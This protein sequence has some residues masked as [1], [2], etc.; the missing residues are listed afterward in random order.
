MRDCTE[1]SHESRFPDQAVLAWCFVVVAA[2]L[3][4]W[5]PLQGADFAWHLQIG[6]VAWQ[7]KTMLPVEIFSF[8]Q[9]GRPWL[10]KD[11][12]A[13]ILL[14]GLYSGL[15]VWGFWLLKIL[16]LLTIAWAYHRVFPAQHRPA[17][18]LL[19]CLLGC[20][21]IQYRVL[22][23][24]LLFSLVCF[25]LMVSLLE[26]LRLSPPQTSSFRAIFSG[27][28]PLVL[29]Q[30]IWIQLHRGALLG[31]AI[32]LF[33]VIGFGIA[34]VTRR[35]A[36]SK[37]LWGEAPHPRWMLGLVA[38]WLLSVGLGLI[39][40]SGIHTFTSS[41]YVVGS[42]HIRTWSSEWQAISWKEFFQYFPFAAALAV[43]ACGG[44]CLHLWQRY[45]Y[46][47]HC[48]GTLTFGPILI[49][50]M[51]AFLSTRTIRWIPYL[52][53]F[54][55]YGLGYLL[56][57]FLEVR[58]RWKQYVQ[59]WPILL[60]TGVIGLGLLL[61]QKAE[62]WQLG[63][64]LDR[65][66]E[67]AVRFM[68]QHKLHGRV[69]HAFRFGGYLMWRLWPKVLVQMDGRNDM[70]YPPDSLVASMRS[71]QEPKIFDQWQRTYGVTC[72]VASNHLDFVSHTFL[73]RE[74]QWMMVYWSE[75]A[76]IYVT[77][78]HYP[79]LRPFR[80]QYIHPASVDES[81]Y[82][83]VRR[84][85]HDPKHMAQLQAELQRMVE[86]SPQG[87]RSLM[88]MVLFFHFRGRAYRK[89]RDAWAQR[90]SQ[91]AGSH[92]TVQQLFRRLGWP[93]P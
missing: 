35:Y 22:E 71:Q 5:G 8:T 21:A 93:S 53:L 26:R 7:Q 61:S 16:A 45:R 83:T 51:F 14:Y 73:A 25:A 66:P 54:S 13:D 60:G 77:R 32:F 3:V 20:G 4:T 57:E 44:A 33:W 10:Y 18:F 28:A 9:Q 62:P 84:W 59:R 49:L 1:L 41:F 39:N 15:G 48:Q 19:L 89:Q 42:E 34:F 36:W 6:K 91:A 37:L 50:G 64:N 12:I 86:A 11:W 76:V 38:A 55:A 79:N 24:P 81:V 29:L 92:P 2:I 67:G 82:Y 78:K 88:G 65:M 52:S 87:I 40:P 46:P 70:V 72:V 90:L 23:R 17:L 47:Q 69:M 80:Y 31:Y 68:E 74:P 30:W 63:L 27:L 58:E 43:G 85:G 56:W 75:A